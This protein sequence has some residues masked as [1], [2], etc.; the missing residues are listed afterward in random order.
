MNYKNI[1]FIFF[2]GGEITVYFF[3]THTT[4]IIINL[5]LKKIKNRWN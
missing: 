1:I 5:I 2:W 3:K 4:L